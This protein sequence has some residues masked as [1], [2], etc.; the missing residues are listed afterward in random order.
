MH[1][2]NTVHLSPFTPWH[3]LLLLI[4]CMQIL[5]LKLA[6]TILGLDYFPLQKNTLTYSLS[7]Y[8]TYLLLAS[9]TNVFFFLNL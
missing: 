6:T 7:F 9:C 4:G 8:G 3:E 2:T 5:I 1:K